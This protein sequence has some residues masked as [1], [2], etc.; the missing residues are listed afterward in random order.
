M[1][2]KSTIILLTLSVLLFASCVRKNTESLSYSI[3]NDLKEITKSDTLRVATMYGSTSYFLFRDE[4]MGFD[5][6]MA[7]NLANYLHLNL[8]FSIATSE[9]EMTQWLQENKVDL[10]AYNVTAT[11][12]LKRNFSFVLPQSDSYQVLVQNMGVNALSDVT[13]LAGKSVYVKENSI[14]YDRLHALNDE[15]GGTI[16]IVLADD[17]LSNDDLI[18]MVAEHKINYTLAYHNVALL[19]KSYSSSLD[20]H[21]SV[22][23]DQHNGWLIRKRSRNLR[24]AIERWEKLPVTE[25][26]QSVLFNKYWEKSPY[27][28]LREAKIPKGAISPYDRLFKKYAPSINWDWRLLAALAFHESRFDPTDESWAG[29]VGLMQLMPRTALK[30]G[31]DRTTVYDPEM[32]IEASV[33]Y[34]KSLNLAFRQIENKNERIKFILAAYNSG[35]AHVLDAMALASKFGK[36][37]HVWFNQVEYFLLKKNDPDFYNDPVVKYGYFHGKETVK[38]VQSTLATY[39]KYQTRK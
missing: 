33:Q 20:C 4:L 7:E 21:M 39:E 17:S 18:D 23:F 10:V 16:N 36:N 15:I 11:K 9:N 3:S 1:K 28:A 35:P 24:T 8:E 6:E 34:I 19:H 37:P 5:Y 38:Y 2:N 26:I 22:G 14:F 27:F 31:L 29:A 13:E 32:N 30:F 12:E 25:Q